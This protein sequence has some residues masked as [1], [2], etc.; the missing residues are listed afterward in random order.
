MKYQI[1]YI[2]D[3]GDSFNHYRDEEGVLE[4]INEDLNVAKENL[5]RIKEHYKQYEEL[6]YSRSR[7]KKDIL[8]SNKDKDWFVEDN[9]D[10]MGYAENCIKLYTDDG[11]PWQIWAPWCGYFE[12]LNSA[13]IVCAVPEEDDMEIIIN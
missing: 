11:K 1:K 8:E 10:Y 7:E 3:T 13:R 12:R 6:S 5:K 4:L 9:N 2:Y